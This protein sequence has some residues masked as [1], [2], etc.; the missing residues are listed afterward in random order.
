MRYY[1]KYAVWELTLKCN[2]SCMHCGSRAGTAR[3]RELSLDECLDV[4]QQLIDMGCEKITLIGGEIFLYKDWEVLAKKFVDS[5]VDT[6]IITNAYM[7]GNAQMEQIKKSGIKLIGI[8]LDGLEKTHNKIRGNDK[9]FQR[10]IDT[11]KKL[12]EAGY[13]IAVLTTVLKDNFEELE[14]I[15]SILVNNNIDMWQLQLASPMGNASDNK[16]IFIDYNQVPKLTKFVYD[17]RKLG[18]IIVLAGDNIG[19]FDPYE[20]DIRIPNIG[21]CSFSGCQAGLYVVGIDSVGNVKGCE[22]LYSDNFIEG[23]L[24]HNTLKE[25][26]NKEDAFSYNRNF[27]PKDL[28]GHCKGCDMGPY[29]A[30]GC[31]QLSYFSSGDYYNN[32][33]CCY[34]NKPCME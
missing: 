21:S 32:A 28:K 12:K 11:F 13:Q 4:A 20:E 2:M 31:R 33:Y 19:Y 6:N 16:D 1:P 34:P 24:R 22:S 30:G 26:W 27:N 25:I 18:K 8:S 9:S 23:N 10:V 5:S 14:E 17:K 3:D 7:I 15:Y 29:C